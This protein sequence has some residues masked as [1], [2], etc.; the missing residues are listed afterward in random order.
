M[1]ALRD[2]LV[3]YLTAELTELDA[4]LGLYDLQFNAEI[5]YAYTILD[6]FAKLAAFIGYLDVVISSSDDNDDSI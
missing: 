1:I 6:N 2:L 4:R 5:E 3:R